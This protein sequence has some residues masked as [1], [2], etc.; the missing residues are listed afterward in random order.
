MVVE[1][2]EWLFLSTIKVGLQLREQDNTRVDGL[3]NLGPYLAF[4]IMKLKSLKAEGIA[5]L[6]GPQNIVLEWMA[7]SAQLVVSPQVKDNDHRVAM[8][9][10]PDVGDI[11]PVEVYSGYLLDEDIDL[12]GVGNLEQQAQDNLDNHKHP[13]TFVDNQVARRVDS[14][15]GH[16]LVVAN[17]HVDQER[18]LEAYSH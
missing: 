5:Q 14:V 3:R 12:Q 13:D 11:G 2:L 4:D 9:I 16:L 6:E 8:G 1:G 7:K 18:Q 15:D 10:G 17:M